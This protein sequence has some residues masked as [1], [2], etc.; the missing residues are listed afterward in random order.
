MGEILFSGSSHVQIQG[1]KVL[2]VKSSDLDK[3]L[4]ELVGF[5]NYPILIE[6]MRVGGLAALTDFFA[7]N[8]PLEFAPKFNHPALVTII[9]GK[10]MQIT[11]RL[12]DTDEKNPDYMLWIAIGMQ[13]KL[14]NYSFVLCKNIP[15]K[16]GQTALLSLYLRTMAASHL[17]FPQ[18]VRDH[19][20]DNQLV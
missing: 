12:N 4:Y 8:Q 14:P 6:D 2:R 11:I 20:I 16:Q 10:G 3:A 7:N 1:D 13:K 19:Q 9:K 18:R 15:Y 5:E 17:V